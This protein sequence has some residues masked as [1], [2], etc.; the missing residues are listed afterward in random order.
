M[1]VWHLAGWAVRRAGT[2]PG[3]L[4]PLPFSCLHALRFCRI[5]HFAFTVARCAGA[6]LADG[7]CVPGFWENGG[8]VNACLPFYTSLR[9]Y[10][11]FPV[12]FFLLFCCLYSGTLPPKRCPCACLVACWARALTHT[13]LPARCWAAGPPH[14]PTCSLVRCPHDLFVLP[15]LRCGVLRSCVLRL[16]AGFFPAG[17]RDGRH[18][19]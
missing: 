18:G 14:H 10:F 15:V 1:P 6:F 16:Y 7:A 3:T 4:V 13:A 17:R 11:R 8:R 9:V 5:R 2:A 19:L 12:S